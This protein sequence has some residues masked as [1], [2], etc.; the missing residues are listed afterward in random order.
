MHFNIFLTA[1]IVI[2]IPII[3]HYLKKWFRG[4][5][6]KIKKDLNGKIIIITGANAGIG[7]ETALQLAKLNATIILAGRS[8]ERN[9]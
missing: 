8:E 7:Y 2:S 6:C 3:L 1:S 9:K 5:V 4:G